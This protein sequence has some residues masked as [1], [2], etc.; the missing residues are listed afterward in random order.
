MVQLYPEFGFELTI[1]SGICSSSQ[2]E[3]FLS[4]SRLLILNTTFFRSST[5]AEARG[6]IVFMTQLRDV[7]N[8]SEYLDTSD[9]VISMHIREHGENNHIY[10]HTW[11]FSEILEPVHL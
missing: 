11:S 2:R 7:L 1:S 10:F 8:F 4:S 9:A 6:S 5:V 3:M